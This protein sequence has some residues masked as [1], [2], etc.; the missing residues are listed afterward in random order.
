M[1]RGIEA[2]LRRSQGSVQNMDRSQ[3][4]GILHEGSEVKSKAGKI[5]IV[6]VKI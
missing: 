4:L 3:E 6:L 5:V 1:L 2:F